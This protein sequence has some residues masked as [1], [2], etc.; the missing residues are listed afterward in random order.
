MK[1]LKLLLIFIFLVCVAYQTSFAQMYHYVKGVTACMKAYKYNAYYYGLYEEQAFDEWEKG[2][3]AGEFASGMMLA[4]CYLVERGTTRDLSKATSIIESWIPKN[5]DALVFAAYHWLPRDNFWTEEDLYQSLCQD[6]SEYT[7]FRNILGIRDVRAADYGGVANFSKSFKYANAYLAKNPQNEY[8]V[9]LCKQIV[10]YGYLLGFGGIKVNY[11]KALNY[12][13]EKRVLYEIKEV[14][15]GYKDKAGLKAKIKE[16]LPVLQEYDLADVLTSDDYVMAVG[17][18][19]CEDENRKGIVTHYLTI[20]SP[21]TL[22][23]AEFMSQNDPITIGGPKSFMSKYDSLSPKAKQL[24]LDAAIKAFEEDGW[25]GPEYFISFLYYQAKEGSVARNKLTQLWSSAW[26]Y[27]NYPL[28][29][30]ASFIANY[31]K[32]VPAAK[33]LVLDEAIE[34]ALGEDGSRLK[35]DVVS[36]L[37]FQVDEDS[38]TRNQLAQL[39]CNR[40][41]QIF[42]KIIDVHLFVQAYAQFEQSYTTSKL[43]IDGSKICNYFS[44]HDSERLKK[45]M[46]DLAA[47]ESNKKTELLKSFPSTNAVVDDI[48]K[49]RIVSNW[50][51]L[52]DV[53]GFAQ[54]YYMRNSDIYLL[55]KS[56]YERLEALPEDYRD[57]VVRENNLSYDSFLEMKD[58]FELLNKQSLLIIEASDYDEYLK[59]YPSAYYAEYCS[60][61]RLMQLADECTLLTPKEDIK[62]LMSSAV[63]TE[64][65]Q[66]IKKVTKKSYLKEKC[67]EFE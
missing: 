39:W 5:P 27:E 23:F 20:C 57:Y 15:L 1:K 2:H 52:F 19:Y 28:E 40:V 35:P 38:D 29:K 44:T 46:S 55:L 59:K 66:Y 7:F 10:G 4:H 34:L 33:Q 8:Y 45:F 14:L 30:P 53:D 25:A 65:Q 63:Y 9:E 51:L 11:L 42:T 47:I 60:E 49:I 17:D 43:G 67:S 13:P 58:L 36:F 31:D 3:N 12:L 50:E 22:E 56:S 32:L 18:A 54:L 37:Y 48:K 41:N 26:M 24:A 6:E 64:T 21:E 61:A 16:L 62:K